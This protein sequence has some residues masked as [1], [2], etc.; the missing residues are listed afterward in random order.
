VSR[1]ERWRDIAILPGE[2][3]MAR[4]KK[5]TKRDG[6]DVALRP[7]RARKAKANGEAHV[8]ASAADAATDAPGPGHNKPDLTDDEKRVLLLRPVERILA[9]KQQQ[10]DL[11]EEIKDERRRLKSDGFTKVEIDYAIFLRSSSEKD[12][13]DKR[14]AQANI[15]RWLGHPVGHQADLFGDGIDR[16]PDI[17]LAYQVGKNAGILNVEC[18]VPDRW[19]EASEQGQRWM[20]GWHDGREL[21]ESPGIKLLTERELDANPIPGPVEGDDAPGT[22][23]VS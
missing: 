23:S 19:S 14:Q 22:Y 20:Q 5:N 16:T 15:A 21:A 8:E 18:K 6:D 4:P 11:N 2:A 3:T 7:K 13:L 17:D 1:R 9:L 12:A 10:K